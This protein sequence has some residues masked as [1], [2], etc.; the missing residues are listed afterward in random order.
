MPAA[1]A[2][3]GQDPTSRCDVEDVENVRL[4]LPSDISALHRSQVC[5]TVVQQAESRVREPQARDA[6]QS[7]R[8]QLH[9]IAHLMNYKQRHVRHQG[10][11][12]RAR[13]DIGKH[14][15]RKQRAVERYR[16][17][18]GA[19]LA[20]RGNGHWEH[21]LAVL[22]DED[23]RHLQEDDEKTKTK[24]RKRKGVAE[25]T[26]TISWI[27]RGADGDG[28]ES[29]TESLRV[30]WATSRAHSKR[31]GEE[32]KLVPEEMRRT[33]A[34]LEF[35]E[36]RWYERATKREVED[37]HLREGLVAYALDQ[38]RI[39]RE[40][41]ATFR[42]VCLNVALEAGGGLGDEW[43]VVEGFDSSVVHLLEVDEEYEDV[44]RMH[45][46]DSEHDELSRYVY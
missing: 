2:V 21:E 16:R 40:I 32:T 15:S 46:L 1:L 25:G 4:G 35:E 27:W 7:I 36:Q 45:A 31:W 17:A 23:V 10:A 18:R 9:T 20:L 44:V 19:L 6:L 12:T 41:R 39:R 30:E 11:S 14:D 3:L 43:K 29:A 28:S 24:K 42:S 13:A 33:L 8:R 34:T 5:S 38:A 37:I 22:H 26:R